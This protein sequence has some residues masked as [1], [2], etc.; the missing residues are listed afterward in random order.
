MAPT[1]KKASQL[2]ATS[3]CIFLI[4]LVTRLVVAGETIPEYG[5]ATDRWWSAG[6]GGSLPAVADYPNESGSVRILNVEGPIDTSDHAS[7]TALGSNGRACVT[8]HQPSNGMGLSVATIRSRWAVDGATDPLFAAI[9]GSNCPHLPQ[10]E[11]SSHSL[12]LEKGLFRY[13]RRRK[14][15]CV[16][17][18]E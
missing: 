6:Q 7:F 12:L 9:D 3:C 10:E 15:R 17:E 8:C 13:Q 18:L 2:S 1:P 5:P 16:S 14:R 11:A 4:A